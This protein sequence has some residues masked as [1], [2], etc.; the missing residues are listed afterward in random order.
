[1]DRNGTLKTF[2]ER[3]EFKYE[4]LKNIETARS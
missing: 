1:M 4:E 3:V 2:C